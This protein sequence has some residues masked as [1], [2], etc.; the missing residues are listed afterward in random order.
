M[1]IEWRWD[2]LWAILPKLIEATGNT[3]VAA[4]TGYVIALSVGLIFVVLQRSSVKLLTI[5]TREAVEFIRSTPLLVQLFFIFYV[6]PQFGINASA[7]TSGMLAIGFYYAAYMSEIYR[8]G[9]EAV[10]AAQWEACQALNLSPVATYWRIIIP[11]ALPIA[12]PGMGNLLVG[13]FKDTP[14]LSAI[15]VAELMHMANDIG[16]EHYRFLEPYT[17]VGII[18][19]GISLPAAGMIKLFERWMRQRAGLI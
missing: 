8:G 19:L 13:I 17:A 6:A 15:G 5:A 4:G 14:I 11:Q 7:W 18:F 9:L 12:S 1:D 3:L 16:A 2:F 10:P